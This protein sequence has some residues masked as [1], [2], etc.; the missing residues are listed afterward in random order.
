MAILIV[1][2]D[3]FYASQLA[4]T[5]TDSGVATIRASTAQEALKVP[6]EQFDA[7]IIDVMLPNDPDVSG[8]S[9]EESRAGFLTGIALARRLLK[10]KSDLKVVLITGDLWGSDSEHWAKSKG[11]PIVLKSEGLRAV[12]RALEDIGVLK[13]KSRP[14]AFIVHGHDEKALFELKNYLQNTLHWPEPV[15]LREQPNCGRTI[16]EKFED[17]SEQIDCVFVLLTPDDLMAST[18]N[19]ELRRSRQNVIFE[20]GFFYAQLGRRSGRV[21]VLHKGP[22]E[23]PSDIQGVIWISIDNGV[24]AAGEEIRRETKLLG[25]TE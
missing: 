9:T 12:R 10:E 19:K 25:T 7:A 5:L 4:E 16:I 17:L 21:I 8:I 18:T 15:V 6:N 24:D 13:G 22:N 11:I 23:L 2:D 20:L 3:L 14:R 1:E